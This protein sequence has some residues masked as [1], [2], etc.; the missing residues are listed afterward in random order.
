[1]IAADSLD[2]EKGSSGQGDHP[3]PMIPKARVKA[4]R[5]VYFGWAPAWPPSM[6]KP[7]DADLIRWSELWSLPQ[8]ALWLRAELEPTVVSLVRL[9]QRCNSPRPSKTA[10]AELVKLRRELGLDESQS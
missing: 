5:A 2:A 3:D 10:E 8:A 1:M 7:S 6:I 4:T 9:E